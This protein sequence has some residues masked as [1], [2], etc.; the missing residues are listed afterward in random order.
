MQGRKVGFGSW[1]NRQYNDYTCEECYAT[2]DNKDRVRTVGMTPAD[3]L[4]RE[5][6]DDDS[7]RASDWRERTGQ[8]LLRMGEVSSDIR[9]DPNKAMIY[10]EGDDYKYPPVAYA[11]EQHRR[12]VEQTMSL[13]GQ[14]NF[15]RGRH[16]N[17][18]TLERLK[19]PG[20]KRK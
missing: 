14:T 5:L 3:R 17:Q 16:G 18:S 9:P 8:P 10:F 13:L 19:N 1:Y 2:K 7:V 15:C 12:T 11:T 6:K 4:N 20:N